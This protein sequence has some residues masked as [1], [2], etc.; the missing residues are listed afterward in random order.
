MHVFVCLNQCDRPTFI[1]F[2]K[3]KKNL[4]EARS[5]CLPY[6]AVVNHER[7]GTPSKKKKPVGRH[8]AYTH[9]GERTEYEE[10]GREFDVM[11]DVEQIGKRWENTAI[12]FFFFFF[13]SCNSVQ[14]S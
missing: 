9:P 13:H 1:R 14:F 5:R 7:S 4:R 12:F 11:P 6:V 3:V 2:P 8:H 10:R